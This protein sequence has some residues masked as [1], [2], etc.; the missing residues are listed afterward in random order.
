MTVVIPEPEGADVLPGTEAFRDYIDLRTAV[1][2]MVGRP[3]IADVFPRLIGLAESRLNRD[4]RM[5]EQIATATVVF[6]AGRGTIPTGLREIIGIYSPNGHEYVQQT[7]QRV[8]QGGYYYSLEGSEIVAP[9][10]E[11][12]MRVDYYATIPPLSASVTTTNWL[13]DLYP[14]LYLYAT[15]FEAAK[16]VRDG[17]LIQTTKMLLDDALNS[18]RADDERT[19]YARARVRVAGCTP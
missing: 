12:D 18:A 5:R 17:E 13:L 1:V 6:T 16:Y 2:E 14:D 4:L 9:R 8:A 3:D 10:F 7:P 19:R 15:G 11:G